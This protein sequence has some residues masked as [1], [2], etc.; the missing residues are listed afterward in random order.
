MNLNHVSKPALPFKG[1]L[2]PYYIL[3]AIIGLLMVATALTGLLGP[4]TV[5]PEED[6]RQSLLPN[7]VVNL[8][9]GVPILV[10]SMWLARRGRLLGLLFWPGALFYPL[11]NYLAYLFALPHTVLFVPYLA[12][13]TLSVYTLIGLVAGIDRGAV[14]AQLEG[15]VPEKL[16]GCIAAGFGIIF[17]LR[18][19][20]VSISA[21]LDNAP[22]AAIDLAVLISDFAISPAMMIGGVLLWQRK[23]LGYTVGLGLLFQASM[24]FIA[25]II[26]MLIQ[27]L[28]TTAD[29]NLVDVLVVAVMGLVCFVPFGLFVRGVA[30]K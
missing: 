18:V 23:A 10:I 13:V 11:Y 21:L 20:F 12:L 22:V 1:S 29:Y 17:L 16:S 15:K 19:V 4:D 9:V 3:T 24:L 2:T 26:F 6:L 25:L 14:G 30:G 7:E 8:F 28:I 27:P 5:Y